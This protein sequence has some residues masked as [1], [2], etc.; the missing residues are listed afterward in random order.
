M[1]INSYL[2]FHDQTVMIKKIHLCIVDT[3][4]EMSINGEEQ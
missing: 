4:L 1:L 2:Y 3:Q